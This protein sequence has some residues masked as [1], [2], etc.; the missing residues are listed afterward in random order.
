MS[1][2]RRPPVPAWW[3]LWIKTS[4]MAFTA[5]LVMANRLMRMAA[6]GSSP[7][8]RDRREFTRMG[9]EKV[10][11]VFESMV[12]AAM[13][14]FEANLKLWQSLVPTLWGGRAPSSPVLPRKLVE[15]GVQVTS[16]ALAP[17][18]TRVMANGRR[19]GKRV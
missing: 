2:A 19:L 3:L 7:G 1:R 15:S 17:S 4:E 9:Q 5:P 6:A 8:T 16:R 14:G 18:H 12:A 10:D 11:A 13:A